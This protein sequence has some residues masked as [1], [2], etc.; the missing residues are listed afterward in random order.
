MSLR[1]LRTS[2][3][4]VDTCCFY[5]PCTSFP[6]GIAPPH[7]MPFRWNCR[8][9]GL[10]VPSVA[11]RHGDGTPPR[12]GQSPTSMRTACVKPSIRRCDLPYRPQKRAGFCL[13]CL[14]QGKWLRSISG[15]I[16]CL[17]EK[18]CL[19]ERVRPTAPGETEVSR[20]KPQSERSERGE[21]IS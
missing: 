16:S 21:K 9:Q 1:N 2:A 14:L 8:S 13:P 10:L 15:Q 7:P 4:V 19:Q 11:P 17:I 3:I 5:L 18:A 20:T 6:L 12:S